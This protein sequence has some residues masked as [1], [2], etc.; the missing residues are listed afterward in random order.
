MS[1][2]VIYLFIKQKQLGFQITK[3]HM[4]RGKAKLETKLHAWFLF[5][6]AWFP[7]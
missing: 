7:C 4:R 2:E 6:L 3:I 5:Y 1:K